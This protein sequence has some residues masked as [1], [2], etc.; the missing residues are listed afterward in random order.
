MHPIPQVIDPVTFLRDPRATSINGNLKR[1][2]SARFFG[3]EICNTKYEMEGNP[4]YFDI[5]QLKAGEELNNLLQ[6]ASRER[7]SAQG[8]APS[9]NITGEGTLK[10]NQQFDLLEWWTHLNGKKYLLTLGNARTKLVRATKLKGDEWPVI[11]RPLF[12]VAHDWDGVS[13]PDLVEDKQRARAILQNLGLESAKAEVYPMYLF[14]QNKIKNRSHLNF[15]FNKFI[16]V[17]GDTNNAVVPMNKPLVHQTVSW[18]MEMMDQSAQRALATPEIQQGIVSKQSR[19]LGELELVTAKVDTRYSLAAK[20]FGWSEKNFWRQWYFLYKTYFNTSID[21]K[22]LRLTG[23]WGA[24]FRE[25]KNKDIITNTDPDIKIESKILSEAKRIREKNDFMGL[26]SALANDPTI[27]RRFA[28]KKL[29]KLSGV[30]E[31]EI[32]ML[33]P[34]TYDELH[35]ED[36]NDLIDKKQVPPVDIREDHAI[37]IQIHSKVEDTDYREN[38]IKAHKQAMMLK[39]KNIMLF[40]QRDQAMNPAMASMAPAKAPEMAQDNIPNSYKK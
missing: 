28:E 20:I 24:E 39:Q 35:A 34:P 29:A 6:K 14:D 19:T 17:S 25:L 5:D 37:H 8:L 27:G 9:S 36:E 40:Q 10:G 1:H 12:P 32:K 11:D 3:R 2:N 15:G 13:I 38:H 26:F 16:P 18:I 22:A 21:K 7:R 31:Q 33:F 30:K 4:A 23:L